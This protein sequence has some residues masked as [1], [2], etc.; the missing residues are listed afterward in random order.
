MTV[1]FNFQIQPNESVAKNLQS[2]LP[3]GMHGCVQ[4]RGWCGEH[5]MHI[6]H[7]YIWKQ[8][9]DGHAGDSRARRNRPISSRLWGIS[10]SID[11]IG[12]LERTPIPSSPSSDCKLCTQGDVRA[13]VKD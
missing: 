3:D 4:P 5:A 6:W 13:H 11:Q 10:P 1:I 8:H 7:T 9:V 2:I 12:D